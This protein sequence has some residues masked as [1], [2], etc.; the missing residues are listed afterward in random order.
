MADRFQP[1]DM[2]QL[3]SGGPIMTVCEVEK[4]RVWTYW[5]AYG[6]RRWH[7]FTMATLQRAEAPRARTRGTRANAPALP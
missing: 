5:F 7:E 2:V 4:Q 6:K 1:G 3:K